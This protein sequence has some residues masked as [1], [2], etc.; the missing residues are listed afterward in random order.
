MDRRA[1][2][3][4]VLEAAAG[5]DAELPRAQDGE[6]VGCPAPGEAHG[7]ELLQDF[8]DGAPGPGGVVEEL[9]G[10]GGVCEF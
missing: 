1:R 7:V 10:V 5:T 8:E 4:G 6:D 9:V 3:V 2:L